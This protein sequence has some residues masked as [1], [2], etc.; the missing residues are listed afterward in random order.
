MDNSN[1]KT[2]PPAEESTGAAPDR[3]PPQQEVRAA[4]RREPAQFDTS[5]PLPIVVGIGASAGGL[6][7]IEEFFRL[8][9]S[10]TGAS[11][12][13]VQ[14]L[15]PDF[16]SLMDEILKRRTAIQIERVTDRAPIL[17]DRI[18]LFPPRTNIVVEGQELA[19]HP[20]PNERLAARP[21]DVFFQSMADQLGSAAI[22]IQMSGTGTDGAH[23]V[24]EIKEAGGIVLVQDPDE[25]GF[26]GMPNAAIATGCA[27]FVLPAAEIATK[28]RD[29]LAHPFL[30]SAAAQG[31]P[32]HGENPLFDTILE[33]I[34]HHTDIDFDS[35]K[36]STILRRIER[37]MS[38][39]QTTAAHEY[40][41]LLRT[42]EQEV[43]ALARDF[44]INVTR[45]FRDLQGFWS[46]R[47]YLISAFAEDPARKDPFRI[48]VAGCATGEEAYSITAMALQT[49]RDMGARFDVKV[50][51]TDIDETALE[52]AAAG[53]YPISAESDVPPAYFNTLMDRV[54]DELVVDP[55]V[56]NKIVFARHDLLR[57][58]PFP[59][60]DMV[61]CRNLLIYLKPEAQERVLA[62]F[63]FA[64][65]RRGILF[66]GSSESVE[67]L[68]KEF[69][70]LDQNWKIF[71]KT[72]ESSTIHFSAIGPPIPPS[73]RPLRRSAPRMDVQE[74]P[75]LRACEHL[76]GLF[77]RAAVVVSEDG[78]VVYTFGQVSR[79]LTLPR[80][81]VSTNLRDM[82]PAES[83]ETTL[84]AIR[85]ARSV[86]G[87]VRIS[88]LT[89]S[90]DSD[91]GEC[92]LDLVHVQG[93]ESH[94]GYDV[95]L[96]GYERTGA[97]GEG[98]DFKLDLDVAS[99]R[100]IEALERE[101][102][103]TRHS[104]QTTIEELETTNEEMQ[105]VN[106]ELL[107]SNE[108]L[109]STNEELHSVNEELFT[110]NSEHQ[111]KIHE[112]G[113]ISAD[114]ENLLKATS[115]GTVFLD[116]EMRV[117]RFTPSAEIALP[118]RAQDLGRSI[119]ELVS[120]LEDV[121]LTDLARSVMIKSE[122]IERNART[123][124]GMPVLVRAHPFESTSSASGGTVLTFVDMSGV[125]D[126]GHDATELA[127]L[128]M[129]ATQSHDFA[130][131]L[132]DQ[133]TTRL[134]YV[135]PGA[136]ALWGL[137]AD[138]SF[139]E[140]LSWMRCIHADD[141]PRVERSFLSASSDA[142]YEEDY[143]VLEPG[144][145]FHWIR[146]RSLGTV[147]NKDGSTV[148]VGIAE[149]ITTRVEADLRHRR[150]LEVHRMAA[151]TSPVPMVVMREDGRILWSNPSARRSVRSETNG[152]PDNFEEYLADSAARKAWREAVRD[153]MSAEPMGRKTPLSLKSGKSEIPC[154]IELARF[155]SEGEGTR[156]LVCQW[157][158]RSG[159][160]AREL[161]LNSK[162]ETFE[163]AAHVD[164]L[165][166]V[167]NRR[168]LER[169]LRQQQILA[170]RRGHEPMMA[171]LIDCD[172][173]KSINDT[174]GHHVG[175][176]VLRE[177]ARRIGETL[178]PSDLLGRVGGDE[179]LAILPETR[180]AEGAHVC[181]KLRRTVSRTP[182]V[183]GLPKATISVGVVAVSADETRIASLVA[184]TEPALRRSKLSG[185]DRV[186]VA[187]GIHAGQAPSQGLMQ[188]LLDGN[189]RVVRQSIHS[190]KTGEVVGY[191]LLS[192][193]EAPYA[194][195][196]VFF[197]ASR[198]L[199]CLEELDLVCLQKCVEDALNSVTGAGRFHV[200]LF[201]SSLLVQDGT[202]VEA[203][204]DR[205]PDKTRF[206]LEIS[207]QQF[208]GSS[209]V[210]RDRI[211]RLR[212]QGFHIAID[213][214]GFGRSALET[215]LTLEPDVVKIDRTLV[216]DIDESAGSRRILD[217]LVSL[218]RPH[219]KELIAEGVEREGQRRVL[220][221]LGVL[222][223]QGYLWSRPDGDGAEAKENGVDQPQHSSS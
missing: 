152:S 83:A 203:I 59:L 217:R 85:Q 204:L 74:N 154:E 29:L 91:S 81:L 22:A 127:N 117:R 220:E 49:A 99:R 28:V 206:C 38:L 141:R 47:Q 182:P 51:A 193:G 160:L 17:P 35:Y 4:I 189:V 10:D 62:R 11:F 32:L 72:N 119:S 102:Q 148:S 158:D 192:R 109:Q 167:L 70:P 60:T 172:R 214:V 179:F 92:S 33:I 84:L 138:H 121:D 139:E 126:S 5:P 42:D 173:F 20:Q 190:V 21:I 180:L 82:L 183:E 46:L 2:A 174:Y 88:K 110:V 108:E 18:Y 221:E 19:L 107:A 58:P 186:H 57:D 213:D 41:E 9:P 116:S 39:R 16:K 105:S 145:G 71:T 198:M 111:Q 63:H 223:A 34:R 25:A 50:F 44:F 36:T 212:G 196:D 123:K 104:L 205:I 56:R 144:G 31:H 98:Q 52:V 69:L 149:D 131:W 118:L 76:V 218:F 95:L 125:V 97:Q 6:E 135:S 86:D 184:A 80:G 176:R 75:L 73:R 199:H 115:I 12:V 120:H 114:L 3:P 134:R 64:L 202:A 27:D 140:P 157:V 136:N 106:E 137:P 187:D 164:P 94:P 93:T 112:L 209:S 208:V 130:F 166:E 194:M 122:I 170:A 48:W 100:Q 79:W 156:L 55:S 155:L 161:E 165:T 197:E 222:H 188:R 181:E 178:R 53:R 96:L 150:S 77:A 201:P 15:S 195:P 128:L 175:D 133:D 68:G 185:R 78:Q 162:V 45:F 13:L 216:R 200:N 54:G 14:H 40:V 67:S 153:A 163:A 90:S 215:L 8:L 211:D 142:P 30:R 146:D 113:M 147:Q 171:V 177:L 87:P 169:A 207:E 1:D 26:D 124:D 191:E 210:L 89:P 132:L 151:E 37:R 43:R 168:G 24:R 66:L 103:S 7:A 61:V 143:R 23:G 101:L 219:H 129:G 159:Q 65:R